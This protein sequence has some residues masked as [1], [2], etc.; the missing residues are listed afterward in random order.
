[1][2]EETPQITLRDSIEQSV[3]AVEEQQETS[4]Q[5]ASRAR[6]EQGRFAAEE[7]KKDS[8]SEVPKN[9]PR[10]TKTG[11]QSAQGSQS[12]SPKIQRPSSWKKE[13]WPV[14][15]KL[16][17]GEQL[18]PEESIKLAEYNAQREQDFAKGVSTYKQ[19]WESAKPI[20]D[21][22]AQFKPLLDQHGIKPTEWIG[23]LGNAHKMLA[24]GSQEQKLSMFVKLAQDYQVPLQ[25]LFTQGQDGKVYFNPQVQAYQQP[26]QNFDPRQAVREILEEEKISQEVSS[27]VSDTEKYPYIEQV[28]DTMAGLLQA[29]LAQ[30]L[31][32]AYDA[33]LRMPSHS[34]L[35]DSLQQQQVTEKNQKMR[36][37]K[38]REVIGA[39]AKAVSP[40]T[41][42]PAGSS[43]NGKAKGLREAIES[44]F[45]E[46]VSSRV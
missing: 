11:A 12:E 16:T 37:Q 19:E 24:L 36:E 1:M 17:K 41:S 14:W 44:S 2:Q 35:F 4:E 3:D 27:F 39:R 21:A 42:T 45:D 25:S 30:D 33:A 15:D 22:M 5:R 7:A 10:D 6:D 46:V 40:R 9:V 28:K 31:K 38:Q 43:S 20:L 29:G 26:Q 23:N 8:I 13:M 34:D 32:S 18:L